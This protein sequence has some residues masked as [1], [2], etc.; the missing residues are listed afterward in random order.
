MIGKYSMITRVEYT[1]DDIENARNWL[2][3]FRDN[4]LDKGLMHETVILSHIIV[5]LHDLKKNYETIV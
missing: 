3:E 5:M 1:S 4:C 2:I